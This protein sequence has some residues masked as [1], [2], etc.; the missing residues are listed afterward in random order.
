MATP[1]I[2]GVAA[3]IK[4]RHPKWSPAAITS[5][6]M[7]S[8]EV[9]DHSGS[10]ILAQDYSDSPILEHVLVHATPFDFGAG[11]INP[12]RAIDP[13]LIFNA[14]FQEYVQFLCAVPGVDDD[15]VRR[16]TGYG[17][18]PENQGWCSDLN[19]PS[20]T[21][22]NLVGSRKVIRRVRNVSSANETYTVTV[23]EPSGVKVSVS[24]QV[25]KIRGLASRE[26]KIVLKATNSTR[27]YS[28]GA[29]VLQGNNNH[30]IR[31]PIAVY[32]STSL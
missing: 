28:F 11:F 25:F 9:T 31:I 23:K 6:M 17:C 20:I 13:G 18:P 2:A 15:Y 10:P 12:A 7:T 4:Q 26:V 19:T 22:S 29:M 21:V 1:H 27:A 14:H 24:P 5:A 32:V 8:A 3:L 30:I 16:V